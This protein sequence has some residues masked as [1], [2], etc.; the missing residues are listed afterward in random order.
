MKKI[1]K[2]EAVKK[3]LLKHKSIN[4]WQAFELYKETRLSAVIFILRNRG[5]NIVSEPMPHNSEIKNFTK[6]VLKTSPVTCFE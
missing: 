6:Y 1:C 2:L 5:W 4:S 3:H